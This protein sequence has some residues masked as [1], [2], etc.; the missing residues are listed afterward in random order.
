MNAIL[1]SVARTMAYW[2]EYWRVRCWRCEGLRDNDSDDPCPH[3]G[4]R[5]VT[6]F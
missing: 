6:P 3:C 5:D 4:E 2:L 1:N